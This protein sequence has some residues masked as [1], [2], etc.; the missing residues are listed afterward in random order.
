MDLKLDLVLTQVLG[1]VL[2]VVLLRHWAWGPVMGLL[3]ERRERIRR[4]LEAAERAKRD[5]AE[6]RTKFEQELRGI[7]AKARVRLQEAV[8]EGQKVA[9]EIKQ[10]AHA[11]ANA[12]LVRANDEI[13]REHDRAKAALRQQVARLSIRTAEK[14]LRT[15]LDDAHQRGLVNAYIDEIGE[16]K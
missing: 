11:D 6:L 12:R 13:A 5:T 3:A 9:A 4:D 14:I 16:L 1:F 8:V 10:Q 15:K 7:D 2:F